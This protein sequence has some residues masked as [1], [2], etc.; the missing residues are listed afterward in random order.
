[1]A[2]NQTSPYYEETVYSKIA[3]NLT[4]LFYLHK[5]VFQSASDS[6]SRLTQC[7]GLDDEMDIQLEIM[8]KVHQGVGLMRN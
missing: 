8:Q 7:R 4:C 5:S 2:I 3:Q 6:T 1:M